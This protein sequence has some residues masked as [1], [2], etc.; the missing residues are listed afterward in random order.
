M[1][2]IDMDDKTKKEI[3][4]LILKDMTKADTSIFKTLKTQKNIVL[5]HNDLYNFL[6]DSKG[7]IK[8]S[9]IKKL[10]FADYNTM[11]S[12]IEKFGTFKKEFSDELLEKVFRY[13]SFS[14]RKVA[15]QMLQ[16]INARVCPYCNRQYTFTL[17][18]QKVRPQFDHYF[19]KSIYP[20]LALSV[21]NLI[22]SC[23]I[24]NQAKS[25][26][27]TKHTPILYP[28]NEEFGYEN[29]FITELAGTNIATFRQ[30]LSDNFDIRIKIDSHCKQKDRVE[31]QIKQ[32][33]LQDLYNEH[34]D[35][36]IDLIRNLYVNTPE[37]IEEIIRNFPTL[38]TN[39]DE[40]RATMFMVDIRKDSW[41]KRPLSKL[42]HDI[43][44]DI[45]RSY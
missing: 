15:Y 35:F 24:C 16:K 8:D 32:L 44:K 43:Y 33:H 13:N 28:Y 19:P 14:S 25:S 29:K 40:V 21:F 37:R 7:F 17:D 36:V 18:N 2:K 41:G 45:D 38:F 5:K 31:K 27:D 4:E 11:L 39:A 6:Y 26:L 9:N 34:K 1:I 12:L 23:P 22:P 10:L 30:G 20:Y 3:K 42:S